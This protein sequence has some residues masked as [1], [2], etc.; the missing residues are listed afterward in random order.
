MAVMV[1]SIVFRRHF[2]LHDRDL[3]VHV[4]IVLIMS[5]L[6][7]DFQDVIFLDDG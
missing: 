1:Q 3:V 2:M 6:E 7:V 5:F 4:L